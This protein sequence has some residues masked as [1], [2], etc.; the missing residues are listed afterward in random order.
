M[1]TTNTIKQWMKCLLSMLLVIAGSVIVV[2]T[3]S[4][5]DVTAKVFDT[6]E[7]R[8]VWM[9]SGP[10]TNYNTLGQ[11][12]AGTP[13]TL[14]CYSYGSQ[15]NAPYGAT[16]IWYKLKGRDNTWV[17][18]GYIYTGSD[19]PV[20]GACTDAAKKSEA[21]PPAQKYNR[22]AAVQWAKN[23]LEDPDRFDKYGDC[24][25]YISQSLWAGGLPKS[26]SWNSVSKR[27]GPRGVELTD[28]KVTPAARLAQ[29]FTDHLTSNG[30]ATKQEVTD[31]KDRSVMGARVGDVIVYD[32][33]A[34]GI[35]DHAT[36]VTSIGPD[37]V[38]KV[39]QHGPSYPD[40]PWDWS[41]T[42]NMWLKSPDAKPNAKAYLLR[43]TY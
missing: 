40:K 31:W 4:A 36:I 27:P 33:E 14:E 20:T 30:L 25:W 3:A 18:D 11:L 37:G 9:R 19:A 26:R 1:K 8:Y 34:D 43:I 2:P 28:D 39:T 7:V 23:H 22:T 10:G 17:N 24:T 15:V 41:S 38:V 5:D 13:V 29:K 16:N 35:I 42:Q 12:S 21:N 32:F 6:P